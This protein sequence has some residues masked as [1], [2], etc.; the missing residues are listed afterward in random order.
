MMQVPGKG[1]W[2]SHASGRGVACGCCRS[3]ASRPNPSASPRALLFAHFE[4]DRHPLESVI[5]I[6]WN[7]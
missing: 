2:P 4:G 6:E 3:Q 7:H 1:V 5:G